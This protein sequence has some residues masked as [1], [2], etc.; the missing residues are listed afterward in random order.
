MAALF[1]LAAALLLASQPIAALTPPIPCSE[2]LALAAPGADQSWV[3]AATPPDA[4]TAEVCTGPFEE[5]DVDAPPTSALQLV[6]SDEFEE[7][8]QGLA[9]GEG[10]PRW[11]AG[12]M[13]Y[14]GTED[15]EVY[16]PEQVTTQNGSLSLAIERTSPGSVWALSQQGDGTVWNVTDKGLKSGYV[17]SWNKACFTGG[18]VEARVQLPGEPD[19]PGFWP[20]LWLMGN[21]G[22]AGHL[23]STGGMWPYSYDECGGDEVGREFGAAG[24]IPQRFSACPDPPAGPDRARWGLHAGQGRGAPE[25]DLLEVKTGVSVNLPN[26]KTPRLPFTL[27]PLHVAPMQ[28]AGTFWTVTNESGTFPGP[29]QHL[30]KRGHPEWLWTDLEFWKGPYATNEQNRPGDKMRDVAGA[31]A[32]LEPS[33]WSSYHTF[34]LHWAPGQHL[35][36]FIDGNFVYEINS[37]ALKEYS[38][39][40]YTVPPRLIPVEPMYLIMNLALSRSFGPVKLDDLT[41]PSQFT[42]DYVRVYQDPANVSVSCS[43]PDFPTEQYIACNRDLYLLTQEEQALVNATCVNTTSCRQEAHVRYIGGD[44]TAPDGNL[45]TAQVP[46]A[47]DCCLAC[48]QLAACGAYTF[49]QRLCYFKG[50]TNW[51]REGSKGPTDGPLSGVVYD[52]GAAQ[53]RRLT[54]PPPPPAP[55]PS[56]V[57]ARPTSSS[58]PPAPLPAPAPSSG[59]MQRRSLLGSSSGGG[60]LHSIRLAAAVAALA[61]LLLL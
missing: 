22:R 23:Q 28:P 12:N 61:L 38:N 20:A 25:I 56:P 60:A 49:D 17:D 5:C 50:A 42:I 32:Q 31:Y 2:A 47:R 15:M 53:P 27:L 4:C 45:L 8:G 14:S 24:P 55:A 9:A 6:F 39:G 34:G 11:T 44:L 51:T 36:W 59:I 19:V 1:A 35:R 21:L 30:P 7:E 10:N 26:R 33:F 3:D 58:P 16:L 29:G 46:S 43:P 13:W 52:A 57:P 18:Y 54:A 41:F 48:Q 37:E 40:T